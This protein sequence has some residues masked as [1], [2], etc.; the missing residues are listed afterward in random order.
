MPRLSGRKDKRSPGKRDESASVFPRL[1]LL[2]FYL[3]EK[4]G[5]LL[6]LFVEADD[7]CALVAA[8]PIYKVPACAAAHCAVFRAVHILSISWL[9]NN[10]EL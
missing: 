6:E 8:C 1:R 10:R 2:Y 5:G 9:Y 7:G 4:A 3:Y